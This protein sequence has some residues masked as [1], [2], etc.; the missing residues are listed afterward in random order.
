MQKRLALE[1]T[2][3]QLREKAID[4]MWSN[5]S[6]PL[7]FHVQSNFILSS[8]LIMTMGSAHDDSPP[9]ARPEV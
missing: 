2:F 8:C 1:K 5:V 6:I 3:K 4:S 9:R 7:P